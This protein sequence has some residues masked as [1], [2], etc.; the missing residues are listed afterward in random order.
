MMHRYHGPSTVP[1]VLVLVAGSLICSS[2]DIGLMPTSIGALNIRVEN[3]TSSFATITITPGLE[4]ASDKTSLHSASDLSTVIRVSPSSMSQGALLCSSSTPTTSGFT[5][6]ASVGSGE[7][8]QTVLLEGTGTGTPGFDDGS[9]GLSGERFMLRDTHYSCGETVVIRIADQD[10]QGGAG[11]SGTPRGIIERYASAATIPTRSLT[12]DGAASGDLDGDGQAETT[13]LAIRITNLTDYFMR[14]NLATV[15]DAEGQG[16]DINV[17]PGFTATGTATCDS[18]FSLTTTTLDGLN[19]A[20]VVLVGDGTG[21]PGFDEGSIGAIGDRTFIRGEHFNC[22]DIV[23]V[24]ITNAGEPNR[25][26]DDA[27]VGSGTVTIT[28]GP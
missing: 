8:A 24:V 14:T 15:S 2:C 16:V 26:I 18:R 19:S 23:T 3:A 28:R 25:N 22:G 13:E 27:P 4:A 5:V 21:V 11:A 10:S 17:P 6:T 7:S 12:P 9:I 1:A 20:H